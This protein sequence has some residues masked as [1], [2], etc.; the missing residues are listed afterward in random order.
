MSVNLNESLTSTL[1]IVQG[2]L[3]KKAEVLLEFGNVPV[4][5]CYPRELNQALMSMILN[6]AQA[7]EERGEIKIRTYQDNGFACIDISDD[8][9]GISSEIQKRIFEPFFT[10]KDVGSGTG[11]GLTVAYNTIVTQHRGQL[12]V[13]SKEGK[14][15][16][17]TAKI[18]L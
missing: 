12:L 6:A 16:T 9:I 17:F 1:N 15:T 18:P 3:A 13:N 7:I 11:M 8:G 14:G 4:V 10:T 5:L 2:E